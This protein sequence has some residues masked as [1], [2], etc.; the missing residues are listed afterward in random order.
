M[1]TS[2]QK[3]LLQL[4]VL[5]CVCLLCSILAYFYV[6]Q[7]LALWMSSPEHI[8]FWL[9]NREVTNIG[10]SIH[11]FILCFIVIVVT[12]FMLKKN[13]KKELQPKIKWLFQWAVQFF[14]ALIISGAIV[15]LFKFLVGRQRPH[16]SAIFESDIFSP[17]TTHWHWHSFPSGHSQTLFTV[18]VFLGLLWPKGR[19]LLFFLT[20]ALVLTR[21]F[22]HAHFVSD[23]IMGGF[24]GY[25]GAVITLL[26][27]KKKYPDFSLKIL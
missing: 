3:I 8:D 12:F 1:K 13:L 20:V 27:F 2:N 16:K 4:L 11:F 14:C 24:F 9:L 7:P 19:V 23:V 10:E 21:A 22:T 15:H 6:D 17:L 5:F 18:F 25:F 26:L